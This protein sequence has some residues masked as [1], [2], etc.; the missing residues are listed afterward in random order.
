MSIPKE[1]DVWFGGG[2]YTEYRLPFI[3][4]IY[5]DVEDPNPK[6]L[7]PIKGCIAK[8]IS[9]EKARI[10]IKDLEWIKI[11]GYEKP[12]HIECSKLPKD[13]FLAPTE[14]AWSPIKK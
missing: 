3:N 13:G 2:F 5:S 10:L 12:F 9:K 7:K 8:E 6:N 11:S 1:V 14:Y 4:P